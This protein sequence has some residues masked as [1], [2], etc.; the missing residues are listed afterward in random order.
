MPHESETGFSESAA[1]YDRTPVAAS[2]I[3]SLGVHQMATTGI[4]WAQMGAVRDR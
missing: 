1:L 4:N 2:G 3:S